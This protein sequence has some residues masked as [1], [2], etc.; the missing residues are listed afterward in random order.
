MSS[1]I[2]IIA[3]GVVLLAVLWVALRPAPLPAQTPAARLVAQARVQ[4]DELRPDT[5]ASLLRLVVNPGFGAGIADRLRAYVLLGVAELQL[6]RA[7]QATQAFREALGINPEARVDSLGPLHPELVSVFDAERAQMQRVRALSLATEMSTDTVVAAEGGGYLVTVLPNTRAWVTAT[8]TAAGSAAP[9]YIDSV[10]ASGPAAFTW[11]L[12]A[13]DGALV[14]SGRYT[15][16][17]MTRDTAGTVAPPTSRAIEV[18]RVQTD[19]FPVPAD[20]RGSELLPESTY[21]RRRPLAP[22]ASGAALGAGAVLLAGFGPLPGGASDTRAYAAGAA[23][24]M[25]ALVGFVRGVTVAMPDEAAIAENRRRVAEN[26]RTRDAIARANAAARA[27]ATV[28]IR[29]VGGQ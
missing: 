11:N 24:G 10:L 20:L 26:A 22:L 16:R 17:F 1:R 25:G 13:A 12:R 15:L 2:R 28:R 19:T 7:P 18:E 3:P 27:Q 23:I 8:V 6:G 14:Q 4:L 29:T 21:A 5:A 9:V